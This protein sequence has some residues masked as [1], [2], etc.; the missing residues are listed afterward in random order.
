METTLSTTLFGK[1]IGVRCLD[2][3]TYEGKVTGVGGGVASL[4]WDDR[5]THIACD[6]IVAAWLKD[7]KEK[8]GIGFIGG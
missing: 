7:P 1:E 8:S 4:T 3:A 2:G 6:K 5:V